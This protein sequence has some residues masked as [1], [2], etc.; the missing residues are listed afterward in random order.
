MLLVYYLALFLTVFVWPTW[1]LWRRTGINALVLPRDDSAHGLIGQWFKLLMVA[2]LVV[3]GLN[4]AGTDPGVMGRLGWAEHG[5]VR[6]IGLLLLTGTLVGIAVAQRHMGQ[7][8]RIGID[9]GRHTRLVTE[10]VFTWSRNPIFLGMR[11]NMLG[12]FLITPNGVTLAI[13]LLSE[14]L[15]AIQVRLEEAHL[16]A[17]HGDE[18]RIYESKVR[19]WFGRRPN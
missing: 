17:D 16:L 9:D 4:A 12:L 8:W 3:S 15:I 14:T 19:R 5:V 13:L 10:G 18:Y 11:I 1:R 2:V 6:S 7:S